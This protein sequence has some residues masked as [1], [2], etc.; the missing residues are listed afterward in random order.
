MNTK[1]LKLFN[2]VCA[3]REA[4]APVLIKDL[5]IVL[6]SKAAPYQVN[7]EKY[8]RSKTLNSSKLNSSFYTSW[9]KVKNLPEIERLIDQV[10]HYASTYGTNFQ[11][12][13]VYK[14]NEKIEGLSEDRLKFVYVR[15]VSKDE[16]VEMCFQLLES[17]IALAQESVE[18]ILS[19]LQSCN[20]KFGVTDTERVKNR[21]ALILICDKMNVVPSLPVEA[22]R[23]IVYLITGETLLIKSDSLLQK[24]SEA[25][26]EPK[27]LGLQLFNQYPKEKFATI[28]NRFKPIFLALKKLKVEPV[29]MRF[30]NR[31]NPVAASLVTETSQRVNQISK[32][33]KSLHVPLEKNLLNSLRSCTVDELKKEKDKLLKTPFFQIARALNYLRQS[34]L[35]GYKIYQIRNGKTFTKEDLVQ[36]SPLVKEQFKKK[37]AYLLELLKERYDFSGQFFHI[38]NEV[39]YAI[40]TSEKAFVGNVPIGT[41]FTSSEPIAA[42]IYWENSGGARDL[43]LSAVGLNSKVGWNAS[44]QNTGLLYSGDMTDAQKGAV[45]YMY[46]TEELDDTFLLINNVYSGKVNSEYKIVL[47]KG[48]NLKDKHM[49]QPKNVWF[50]A[51]ATTVSRQSL[52]GVLSPEDTGSS[53]LIL[54]G[55]SGSQSVSGSNK[56]NSIT[57]EAIVDRWQNSFSLNELLVTLGAEIFPVMQEGCS[58]LS[59]E[60]ISRD[61]LLKLFI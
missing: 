32:L 49:M 31:K 2:V 35:D 45:E 11:S 16:L 34:Q 54:N 53:F 14:P 44:Y 61:S 27:R 51:D 39:E 46:M 37:E 1:S 22:L 40:P 59:P 21:E 43:D 57:R 33:S 25:E 6:D 24:M 38:P 10:L 60:M 23:Y 50:Q 20:Y 4:T 58:D 19:I 9:E 56:M 17:G 8:F 55:G 18:D 29:K 12:D 48:P 52:I 7:I 13:F 5:G 3:E 36:N 42:G 47:G 41:K 26:S 15:G 28:F 30:F